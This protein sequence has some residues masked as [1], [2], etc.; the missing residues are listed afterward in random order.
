MY[1]L[2]VLKATFRDT[3]ENKGAATPGG[4][5]LSDAAL[6]EVAPQNVVTAH[7]NGAKHTSAT[8]PSV[9]VVRHR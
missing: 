5:A 1:H 3:G 7:F 8:R 9:T 4:A 6:R 2:T